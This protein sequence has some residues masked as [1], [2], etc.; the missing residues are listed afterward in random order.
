STQENSGTAEIFCA[1]C[2]KSV[3][4]RI[5]TA[6]GRTYHPEHF[7]CAKCKEPIKDSKFQQHDGEPYCEADY[8]KLFLKNCYACKQPIK[9]KIIKAL[10]VEWHEEHFVCTICKKSLAGSSFLEKDGQ[11]YCTTDYYDKFA[12]RCVACKQPITQQAIIAL[13]GKWHQSCFICYKCKT[14]VIEDTFAV[15]NGNPICTK[16]A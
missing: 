3:E 7:T 10:G 14:P 13:D 12:D 5:L 4:G 8:T 16:C 15:Q 11:P 2:N 1:V 9:Q 6:L